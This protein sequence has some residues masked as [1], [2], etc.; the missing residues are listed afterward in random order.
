MALGLDAI[1]IGS[2]A[3]GAAQLSIAIGTASVG[4]SS[5][6]SIGLKATS[7]SE[8]FSNRKWC[9][10]WYSGNSNRNF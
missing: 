5:S 10:G 1:A 4:G 8:K 6:V 2:T 9:D 7:G 3:N